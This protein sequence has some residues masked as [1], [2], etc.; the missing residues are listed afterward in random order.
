MKSRL[1]EAFQTVT[2]VCLLQ[3][4]SEDGGY[5]GGSHAST[6]WGRCDRGLWI[7]QQHRRRGCFCAGRSVQASSPTARP[8]EAE[9]ENWVREAHLF[10][11]DTVAGV[12]LAF[13][14]KLLIKFDLWSIINVVNAEGSLT[15]SCNRNVTLRV[16]KCLVVFLQWGIIT[17]LFF[18]FQDWALVKSFRR[19]YGTQKSCPSGWDG[20]RLT[21]NHTSRLLRP[22]P[23]APLPSSHTRPI[24]PALQVY[25]QPTS[26]LSPVPQ[27]HVLNHCIL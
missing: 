14:H 17:C 22:P 6:R 13:L 10:S 20:T 16:N 8:E 1:L 5:G 11:L 18:S 24:S 27:V 4:V 3:N 23:A 21:L 12:S 15:F 19:S 7:W 26:P 9:E 2:L 25:C